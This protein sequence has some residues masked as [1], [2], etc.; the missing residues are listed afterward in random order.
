M[1]RQKEIKFDSI[2]Y[3]SEVKLDIV[4]EYAAAYSMIL[5]S[6]KHP[7]LSHAYIDA[8]AGSGVNISRDTGE[9]IPGS[10]LNA[11]L[12]EPPF[13]DYYL[14]D[15]DSV[16]VATLKEIVGNRDNI[17]IYEG[18]SN[19][20][21][22]NEIFLKVLF[23]H[24]RRGLCVLDPYGLHLNWQVIYTAGQMR[25]IDIFVNFPVMDINRNVL[26]RN[27]DAVGP[28]AISRMN[29]FWSDS[30]WRDVAYSTN[31]NLFGHPEKEDNITVAEAFR[32]RLKDVAGFKH[33]SEPLPMRNS[34]NATVYYLLFASQKP[35]ASNIIKD[36]FD[37][38]R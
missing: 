36:I 18:D 12:V 34:R 14:I 2:G 30:S 1:K 13:R 25:S 20:I 26:W 11:L 15:I 32:K 35:V 37:K 38:Y 10:P 7:T 22:L 27:P 4:K 6:Q 24:Y 33:V 8:F 19:A 5:S 28:E 31:Q 16:K 21:L 17:Q 3:W 9:F 29:Q 23:E